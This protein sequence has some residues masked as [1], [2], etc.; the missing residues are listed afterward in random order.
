MKNKDNYKT[1]VAI[2]KSMIDTAVISRDE[3]ISKERWGMVN[4][5]ASYLAGLRQALF[6]FGITYFE[7]GEEYNN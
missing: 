5:Q 2:T 1:S 3:Y 7:D 6:N 4:E